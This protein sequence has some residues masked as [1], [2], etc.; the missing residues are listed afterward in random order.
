MANIDYNS[1][2]SLKDYRNIGIIAHIDAGKTTTTERILFFTGKKHKIGEVHDGA[3]TMDFMLQERERGITIQSAATTCMWTLNDVPHRINIIDT[4]GHVDFTIEVQR[5]LRVLDGAVVLFDGKMGVEPQSETVWRQ[6]TEYGVPRICAINKLDGI[7]SSFTKSLDSITKRLS[8]NAVAI[9]MPIGQELEMYR[10]VD[11]V[12]MKVFEYD[13]K[14]ISVYKVT[15]IPESAMEEAKKYRAIMID[16]VVEF[17]DALMDRYLGGD[18]NFTNEELHSAIRK[19]TISCKF[20]PVVVL[21]SKYNKGIQPLLDIVCRYLPSPVDRGELKGLDVDDDTKVVV[22][23]PDAKEAFAGLVFKVVV[24]Q[25]VGTLAYTRI[26]SGTLKAGEFITN[27]SKNTRERVARILLMHANDREDLEVAKVGDIVALVGLKESFTGDTVC[28][29]DAPVLLERINIPRPVVSLAVEPKTK[30]DQEKMGEVLRK[31]AL[32]DPSFVVKSDPETGQTIISGVGELHLEIKVDLMQRDYKVGVN[33]GKPR[34]AYRETIKGV[35]EGEGKYIKQSGGKG[36]YGHCWLKV[37]PNDGKGYEFVNAIKGGAIP[38]QF[39]KPIDKGAEKTLT[40]GIIGGYPTVDVKVTVFD[41]SYHDVDSSEAAF[42]IASSM[43]LKDALKLAKPILLEPMMRVAV[44][45][46]DQ[47]A[48]DVTGALSSKRGM[49]E[50]M[51]PKDDGVQ[52]IVAEVP[53][54]KM[55]GW[56]NDLRSMTS[57]R[58][59]SAME[60]SKYSEVPA[61]LVQSLLDEAK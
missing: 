8:K 42:E 9:Q 49:I 35:A 12:E 31:L 61:G 40:T 52:E 2:K 45:V 5:S 34:V 4:P 56:T 29:V 46:P 51:N 60:F 43:A 33:V 57:G 36:Q 59:S 1:V 7:G 26:Y 55:F 30:A 32:E 17:E 58:G 39:I 41:G 50:G 3:A 54:S 21:A 25:H 13:P 18:T 16:K 23:K 22:R 44:L 15:E 10:I 53:L 47:Y 38:T 19:A 20:F 28:S 6:A 37:E 27:T 48:G 24:D 14:D 11:L